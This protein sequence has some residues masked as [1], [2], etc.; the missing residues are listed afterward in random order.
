MAPRKRGG[1]EQ[2]QS[3]WERIY[4]IVRHIP[5][6]RVATYG[7]VASLAGMGRNA[8][9]VGYALHAIPEYSAV[10]WHRVINAKGE[11]SLPPEG[12]GDLTQRLLLEREGVEFNARG[13]VDLKVFGWKPRAETLARKT[14]R[15]RSDD[16]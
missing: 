15:Q 10:P 3:R 13:R 1:G 14:R 8:R 16:A 6:G 12:G 2:P 11:I 5:R 4:A 7:Q 9:L